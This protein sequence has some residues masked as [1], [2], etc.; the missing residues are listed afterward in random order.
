MNSNCS[1]MATSRSVSPF[2]FPCFPPAAAG[3]APTTNIPTATIAATAAW[4]ERLLR[5][6]LASF[7][8]ADD[9]R[10]EARRDNSER[11]V[12]GNGLITGIRLLCARWRAR[13]RYA[14][15]GAG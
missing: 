10:P 13:L 4:T 2:P 8:G 3:A 14:T 6:A 9:G 12:D 15:R 5:T 11:Q 1:W 7:R